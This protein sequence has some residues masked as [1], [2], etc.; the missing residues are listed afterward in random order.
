MPRKRTVKTFSHRPLEHVLDFETVDYDNLS[1]RT[2]MFAHADPA[3]IT[4]TLHVDGGTLTFTRSR[5]ALKTMLG[6]VL[7]NIDIVHQP[8]PHL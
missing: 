7:E 8:E 3:V 6:H 1:M 4:L 5:D 2:E